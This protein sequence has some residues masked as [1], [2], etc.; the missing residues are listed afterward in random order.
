MKKLTTISVALC[1]VLAMAL[2]AMA[3][4]VELSGHLR[5]RG[6]IFDNDDFREDIRHTDTRWDSRFRTDFKIS[7]SDNVYLR[8]RVHAWGGG[9]NA[10]R[11]FGTTN[12]WEQSW[13][14]NGADTVS[15]DRAWIGYKTSAGLLEAGRM[16]GGVWGTSFGDY[17]GDFDRIKFTTKVGEKVAIVAIFQKVA[18]VDYFDANSDQDLDV[19]YLAA[20]YGG[21]KVSTGVLA[22]YKRV[23]SAK[24]D[25]F[26]VL[27]YIKAN[28]G[29]ITFQGE[30]IRE[31]GSYN[32]GP[33]AVDVQSDAWSMN[34]ETS[35]NHGMFGWELGWAYVTGQDYVSENDVTW[36]NTTYGGVGQDWDKLVYMTD[37]SGRALLNVYNY[38]AAP[39]AAN[40]AAQGGVN[41]TYAG[42]HLMPKEYLTFSFL[43]GVARA[44][45]YDFVGTAN[46]WYGAHYGNEADL[47]A[48]WNIEDNL[49][50]YFNFGYVWAGDA[51]AQI[52]GL[53]D[54][55]NRDNGLKCYSKLQLNF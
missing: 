20:N 49:D 41:L 3:N 24:A 37:T 35:G 48:V 36:G 23:A 40:S 5:V 27:P 13:A 38:G 28:M 42:V 55:H 4:T 7:A 53:A 47:K 26:A 14:A 45:E 11:T 39:A 30:V 10:G 19:Y 1:L 17:A 18:E 52:K 8:G 29:P 2:P 54:R 34:F 12:P 25:L 44:L 15:V 9:A 33:G 46:D 6:F 21:E 50:F 32:N 22:A 16:L 51:M 43:F 31:F